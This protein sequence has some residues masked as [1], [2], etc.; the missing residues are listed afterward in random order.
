MP[1]L[2]LLLLISA[3]VFFAL[4]I[5]GAVMAPAFGASLGAR[6][7]SRRT[8]LVL[9]GLAVFAGAVLGG[10]G[11]AKTLGRDLVPD[12]TFTPRVTVIVMVAAALSLFLANILRTPQSTTWVT[13]FGIC[14]VG[15]QHQN[16][17]AQIFFT[18]ILPAWFFLPLT[19]FLVTAGVTRIFYPL[20]GWNYRLYEHL[21]KHEWKLRFLVVAASCYV[22]FAIG[23]NN[24]AL[25]VGPL[26][27]ADLIPSARIGLA[28]VA[29]LLGLGALL[30][31][32][33]ASTISN[34][35]VPIGAFSATIC[36]LVAGSLLLFASTNKIPQSAVQLAVGTVFG[37]AWAKD[38]GHA[39]L[40]KRM[41]WRIFLTWSITPL[42]AA[43]LTFLLLLVFNR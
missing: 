10:S 21:L 22:G 37:V 23:T 40:R 17:N 15:L 4:N 5:G 38:G 18:R 1:A 39:F 32:A 25:V 42:I 29:P 20:R 16:L 35:I 8:A 3:S 30:F 2:E 14:V 31:P 43:A 33:P 13:V 19:G 36:N 34:R 28:M 11:V 12:G 9:F 6:L 7:L 41:I 24:V 26:L 27:A